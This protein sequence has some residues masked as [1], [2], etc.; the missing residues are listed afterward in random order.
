MLEEEPADNLE[1]FLQH[2]GYNITMSMLAAFPNQ[3]QRVLLAAGQAAGS[4]LNQSH[5]MGPQSEQTK[6]ISWPEPILTQL[7]SL[8]SRWQ[9]DQNLSLRKCAMGCGPPV[10]NSCVSC[11]YL[12]LQTIGF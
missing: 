6:L 4:L 8:G 7:S 11:C 10:W 2:Q 5:A 9:V 12:S 1:S 3:V